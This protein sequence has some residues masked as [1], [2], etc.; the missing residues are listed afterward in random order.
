MGVK[1]NIFTVM[2]KIDRSWIEPETEGWFWD[3]IFKPY[4]RA[5]TIL[6]FIKLFFAM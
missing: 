3:L 2:L 1:I 5:A 6:L 4:M